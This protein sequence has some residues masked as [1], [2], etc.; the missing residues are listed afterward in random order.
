MGVGSEC[1]GVWACRR[2]WLGVVKPGSVTCH[3]LS[4]QQFHPVGSG[5]R[6][7]RRR[8]RRRK[9]VLAE[10]R[11]LLCL[12]MPRATTATVTPTSAATVSP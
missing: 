2:G 9:R 11:S 12:L 8:K 4:R 10:R 7:R 3:P 6:R 5:K 1:A